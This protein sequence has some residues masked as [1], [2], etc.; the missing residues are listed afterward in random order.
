MTEDA[1][2]IFL[3][4]MTVGNIQPS[5]TSTVDKLNEIIDRLKS[6]DEVLQEVD[7][8]LKDLED[9]R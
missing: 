9:Y 8:R 4:G 1:K 3:S 6:I 2:P 5:A 7:Q